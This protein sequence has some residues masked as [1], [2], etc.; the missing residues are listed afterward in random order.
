MLL[1]EYIEEK[2]IRVKIQIF[3]TDIDHNAIKRAREGIYNESIKDNISQIRLK[4]FLSK[5]KIHSKS[6]LLFVR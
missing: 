6:I 1:Q 5:K 2:N 4:K 3:A